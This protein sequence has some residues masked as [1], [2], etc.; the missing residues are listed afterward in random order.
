MNN[1]PFAVLGIKKDGA[2]EKSVLKAWRRRMRENHPDK[3]DDGDD[4]TCKVLNDAKERALFDLKGNNMAQEE[5]EAAYGMQFDEE[6]LD[7]AWEIL[8]GQR[9]LG[10]T[11]ILAEQNSSAKKWMDKDVFRQDIFRMMSVLL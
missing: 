5:F 3:V 2:T 11:N 7:S 10:D 6:R 8:T 9:D 1:C 4:S